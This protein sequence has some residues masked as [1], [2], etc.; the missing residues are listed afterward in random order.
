[1]TGWNHAT[2]EF[3]RSVF[4]PPATA[5]VVMV[6]A[7]IAV[8]VPT[9]SCGTTVKGEGAAIARGV[10]ILLKDIVRRDVV[11]FCDD[12]T[13][14][15]ADRLGAGQ[16]CKSRAGSKFAMA[17]RGTE[18]YAPSELPRGLV[19]QEIRWDGKHGSAVTTWPWPD[20][21]DKVHVILEKV[22]VRWLI[23]TPVLL[24]DV[25]RCSRLFKATVCG[26]SIAADFRS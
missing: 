2:R 20:I 7:M 19:I 21:R 13:P 12:V 11:G 10:R 4:A 17:R 1:M 16:S 6:A 5:K 8:T 3:I 26:R 9:S 18:Y 14:A 25:R 24:V 22:G 23:A 15:V